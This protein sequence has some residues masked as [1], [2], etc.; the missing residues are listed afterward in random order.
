MR[1]SR[2]ENTGHTSS[3][4]LKSADRLALY[5]QHGS[6]AYGLILRIIPEPE[7]A[8]AVLIDVF[9]SPRLTACAETSTA[10]EIIRLA[11]AK[12]LAARPTSIGP[13]LI[14]AQFP[15]TNDTIDTAKLVFN[16]SFCQGCTPE[17]I[18]EKLKLSPVNVL[19]TFHTYFNYLRSS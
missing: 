13:V 8:Q 12:A 7:L 15:A 17:A 9:T 10:G 6:M 5:D 18:A 19:K 2:Q 11:R 1:E 16:L 3:Q 4:A 14:S